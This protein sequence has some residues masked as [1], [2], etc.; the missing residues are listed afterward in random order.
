MCW[1][2]SN[3]IKM[4]CWPLQG[5]GEELERG[6]IPKDYPEYPMPRGQPASI[7]I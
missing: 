3:L 5:G 1:E 2:E 7:C 6:L 4:G